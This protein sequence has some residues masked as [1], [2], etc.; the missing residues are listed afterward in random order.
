MKSGPAIPLVLIGRG[1]TLPSALTV[2]TD[3]PCVPVVTARCGMRIAVSIRASGRRTRTKVPGSNSRAR[4]G[5]FGAQQHRT[6]RGINRHV[7]ELQATRCRV[8]RSVFQYQLDGGTDSAR[9]ACRSSLA[10]CSLSRS[11]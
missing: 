6:G 1:T 8:D 9:F 5:K 4:I 7:G 10:C 2:I 3:S 11:E